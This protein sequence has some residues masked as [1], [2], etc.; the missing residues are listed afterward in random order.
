VETAK[1]LSRKAFFLSLFSFEFSP[2]FPYFRL[3]FPNLFSLSFLT[4]LCAPFFLYLPHFS[5]S[6]FVSPRFL[7]SFSPYFL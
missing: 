7:F 3:S 1:K 2:S 6:P 4:R 5:I